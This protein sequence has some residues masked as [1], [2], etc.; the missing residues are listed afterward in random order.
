MFARCDDYTTE[1]YALKDT[2]LHSKVAR[3]GN[4][5]RF[6]FTA[7]ERELQPL[8]AQLLVVCVCLRVIYSCKT[9]V[10]AETYDSM[11]ASYTARTK[12]AYPEGEDKKK[13]TRLVT[14][15]SCVTKHVNKRK[16]YIIV[17]HE[18]KNERWKRFCLFDVLATKIVAGDG[19][20]STYV[21]NVHT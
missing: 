6:V 2:S 16:N 14:T 7:L 9:N 8:R 11:Y 10:V 4:T 5:T 13:S 12:G 19:R 20:I 15:T 21:S 3:T 1:R 18:F 17:I